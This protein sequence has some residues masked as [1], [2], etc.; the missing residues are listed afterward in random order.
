MTTTARSVMSG[1]VEVIKSEETVL[2]AA[3]RGMVTQADLARALPKEQ[4]GELLAMISSD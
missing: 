1:N 2:N 3:K 4:A